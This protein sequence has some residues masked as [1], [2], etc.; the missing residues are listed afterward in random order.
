MALAID[1]S[2]PAITTQTSTT[3]PTVATGSFTPP[4]GSLLL[5]GWS[6]NTGSASDPSAPSITDSL[7]GHL[8]YTLVGWKH[9]G[10]APTVDGQ[11]AMWWAVV[12]SS[13]AMTVTVTTGTGSGAQQAALKVWVMT[14]ADTTGIG[15]SGLTGSTSAASIAQ[16]YTAQATGGQS[17]IAVCDWDLKGV[18]TAG[19]G[20]T[21]DGSANVGTDISY[22]FFHRTL[23]D[24]SNGVSNTLNVTIPGTSTNLNWVYAEIKPAAGGAAAVWLPTPPARHRFA[25]RPFRAR[26]STPVRPQADTPLPAGT[27][28][29]PPRRLRGLLARRPRVV[30]PVPAQVV[31]TA[32]A[33]PPAPERARLKGV[34]LFRPRVA[35]PAPA[36]VIVA[37]PAYPP[38]P[39]RPRLKGLRLFRPRAAAPVP[40][41]VVFVAAAYPPQSVRTRLKGLRLFRGHAVAPVPPQVVVVPSSYVPTAVRGRLKLPAL[42][43]H[44]NVQPFIDQALPPQMDP[45]P[46]PKFRPVRGRVVLPP[47]PQS[48]PVV[49]LLTRLKLRLV[50][51]VRPRPTSVVP[52][53]V[54]LIAP[55]R[56]AQATRARRH[57]FAAR[58][59]RGGVDGWMVPGVHLCV[60]PRPN[61][62]ITAWDT[63][64]T[65][66]PSTG[67]TEAPC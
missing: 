24:D 55:P 37:A 13:A 48:Q 5:I 15:A 56:V 34:R 63:G 60:T 30:S 33:Y 35:T 23:A 10:V 64:I 44:D 7:G 66:R 49:P 53:Q 58:R 21:R 43:R 8:T 20:A 19:T 32:P 16:S 31:V 12:G 52:P 61:T 51:A 6:G 11:A 38:A 9:R 46:R 36:Q 25:I 26:V 3:T 65:T 62:G 18:E 28:V 57:Q 22:G 54:I 2:S 47:A 50:K 39:E 27:V 45:R 17:F 14:G 4:A 67:I 40:D 42:R 29:D 41:Q 1:A 59:H